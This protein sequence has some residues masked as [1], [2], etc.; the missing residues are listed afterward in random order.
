MDVRW[1]RQ[2]S[3]KH[4]TEGIVDHS[5]SLVFLSLLSLFGWDSCLVLFNFAGPKVW[6][7]V[8]L[9]LC[10]FVLA[11]TR[12]RQGACCAWCLLSG[13]LAMQLG[14]VLCSLHFSTVRPTGQ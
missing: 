13:F 14:L 11:F 12:C 2:R 10:V 9:V 3:R 8:V 5:F 1:T 6:W 4:K 7:F